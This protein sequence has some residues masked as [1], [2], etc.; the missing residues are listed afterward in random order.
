MARRSQQVS[1]RTFQCNE[2]N[3]DLMKFLFHDD[4]FYLFENQRINL[5]GVQS[6]NIM[7]F[8]KNFK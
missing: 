2:Y 1:K 5:M 7:K 4:E 8:Q 3:F 6:T